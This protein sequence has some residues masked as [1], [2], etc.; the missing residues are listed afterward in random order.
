MEIA[1]ISN[2][3]KKVE[4]V[5]KAQFRTDS[6]IQIFTFNYHFAASTF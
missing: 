2:N 6:V 5:E 1:E 4:L 3:K